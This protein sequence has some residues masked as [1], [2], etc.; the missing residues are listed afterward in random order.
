M[1]EIVLNGR[2]HLIPM[3]PRE[4]EE[5]WELVKDTE[6][7]SNLDSNKYYKHKY[8]PEKLFTFNEMLL[9]SNFFKGFRLINYFDSKREISYV[10]T[11][12]TDVLLERN[13]I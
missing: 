12:K 3:V 5:Y 2:I 4:L 1:L 9:I 13:L 8:E 6:I 7:K 10:I 11:N